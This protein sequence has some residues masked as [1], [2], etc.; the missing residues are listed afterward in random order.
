MNILYKQ[1]A[2]G[3]FM[4]N[5]TYLRFPEFSQKAATLSYDDGVIFDKKLIGI[6]NRYGL[7]ATFNINSGLI[8]WETKQD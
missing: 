8:L 1:V 3:V 4:K 5:Y 7:K 2:S 6:L